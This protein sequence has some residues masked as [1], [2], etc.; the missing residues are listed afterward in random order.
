MADWQFGGND[1]QRMRLAQSLLAPKKAVTN[2]WDGASQGVQSMM[3]GYLM[4]KAN[5]AQGRQNN[6]LADK[7]AGYFGLS[8][9]APAPVA[10][11]APAAASTAVP[12]APPPASVLP[13]VDAAAPAPMADAAAAVPQDVAMAQPGA[14]FV[15][16]DWLGSIFKSG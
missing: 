4:R 8:G 2:A 16:P 3:G 1:A 10:P 13:P 9:T 5:E 14:G 15:P 6:S 7:M 12:V 11:M